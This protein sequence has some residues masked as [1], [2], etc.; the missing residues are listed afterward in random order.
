MRQPL[1]AGKSSIQNTLPDRFN[2]K[3][4]DLMLAISA[5]VRSSTIGTM[6]C[7]WMQKMIDTALMEMLKMVINK[8]KLRTIE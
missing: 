5:L 8:Q 6:S 1:L 7:H 3:T 4:M 2:F